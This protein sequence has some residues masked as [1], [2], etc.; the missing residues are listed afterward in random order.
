MTKKNY[1]L[2]IFFFLFSTANI[3]SQ[4]FDY[5]VTSHEWKHNIQPWID[6]FLV[7]GN[8]ESRVET[9]NTGVAYADFNEDGYLDILTLAQ[10]PDGEFPLHQM[11]INN[12]D[13]TY[14]PDNTL[15]TNPGFQAHGPRKTIVGDFNGDNKPDVVRIGGGHDVLENSNILMSGTNNYTFSFI[16]VVPKSQYHG[17]ASGDLDNDGD[18]DLF[19]GQPASGFAMNDGNGNFTWYSVGEKI[20]NYF[21]EN[22]EVIGPYGV[23]TVEIL[24]VNQDGNLDI[25]VGGEYANALDHPHLMGPTILW[26]DG[27]SNY[28]YDNKTEIWEFGEIPMVDGRAVN[29]NDDISFA[30]INNDGY[31][32]VVLLY[33]RQIDNDPN[34]GGNPSYRSVL[35]IFKG[36]E[37]NEF[38]DV[39]NEWTSS[40]LILLDFPVTWVLLRDV[41]NNGMIDIVESE[42]VQ[43]RSVGWTNC[44]RWEWNGS[45]FTTVIDTDGDGVTDDIDN[46]KYISN[47][48]QRDVDNDGVGDVC[49]VSDI[50][51]DKHIS[52][53]DDISVDKKIN[54]RG[55]IPENINSLLTYEYGGYGGYLSINSNIE[56]VIKKEINL[57]EESTLKIPIVYQNQNIS[58]LDT[59]NIQIL[60]GVNWEKNIATTQKGYIPYFFDYKTKFADGNGFVENNAT[61]DGQ[62]FPVSE[63]Q[64]IIRDLNNDGIKDILGKSTQLYY[65]DGNKEIQRTNIQ[66][67][68]IPEY[69][70]LDEN[71]EIKQYHENYRFPDVFTHNSDFIE[72]IDLDGDDVDEILNVGEHY[73]SSIVFYDNS[74]FIQG[75]FKERGIYPGKDYNKENG[76]KKHRI[77]TIN[78]E[79]L[80]DDNEIIDD[81]ELEENDHDRFVDIGGSAVGDIDKDGDEDA[82]LSVSASGDYIDILR[83]NGNSKLIVE[84]DETKNYNTKPEGANVLIDLNNDGYPEYVFG[85]GDIN[86]NGKIG[87]LNNLS[88]N[89]DSDNPVWVNELE[90]LQGLSPKH[91]FKVDLNNDGKE[92]LLIYRSTGLGNPFGTE[93]KEFLNEILIL[94]NE[95]KNVTSE[96]I[97]ENNT[98]KMFSQKSSM[99]YVDIDGD[100]IK[101]IFVQFFTD[102]LYSSL[103]DGQPYYGYWDKNSD[104]FSYFKGNEDGT[105]NFKL[106]EK[107]TYS[108]ELKEYGRL[109][110]ENYMDNMG[111][112]FQPHDLD[113]DGTAELIHQGDMKNH[114]IIFKYTFD[115]DGDGVMDD[116]DTCPDTQTGETVNSTGCSTTQ[117]SVDDE[118]LENSLKLYPNPV[119]NILTIESKNV[120][121]SKVEIYSILGKKIKEIH[122]DFKTIRTDN[123]S[124][125]MYLIKI[126]SEKGMVM[127]NV[128]FH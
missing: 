22:T 80:N 124:N 33:I 92:E 3:Y 62:F 126:Y 12:G 116:I 111:N 86:G 115:L 107:F 50:L 32:D 119:T 24:D 95:L 38:T 55:L 58:V 11:L 81:S 20:S 69:L 35:Q 117:L 16:D 82:V 79:R 70:F 43:S 93:S 128:I 8:G 73:H 44:I 76:G 71:F 94:N 19:F 83:N 64:F 121:I 31:L 108:D 91:I 114:I 84:R 29:N 9:S 60:K 127:K 49:Y 85:G 88:G 106:T 54:L 26:G 41:D 51:Y 25:V 5:K 102:E 7:N 96:Y 59:L 28:D 56:L 112:N 110:G 47:I 30:D 4:E 67:I 13:G 105:F 66:K 40:P 14:S 72:E 123:L 18:L 118:I 2:I 27:S 46:C 104:L 78:N 125:G 103:N 65:L 90:S 42:K 97:D 101:D 89:F 57:F 48:D 74:N 15:I 120:T 52:I 87:Y 122:S 100:K 6:L 34:N 63:Q 10:A 98:S 61:G 45:S 53:R 36:G 113:G 68:G 109:S 1:S 99:Y 39:T 37:N 77:Y 23:G 75:L 17:F 21:I